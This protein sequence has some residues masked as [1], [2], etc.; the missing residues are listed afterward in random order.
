MAAA[1]CGLSVPE[2]PE[3]EGLTLEDGAKRGYMSLR[4]NA[5]SWRPD[6]SS[7]ITKKYSKKVEKVL[8]KEE[9]K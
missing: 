1:R 3:L 7:E 8:G 5:H 2:M 4:S 6:T 9:K